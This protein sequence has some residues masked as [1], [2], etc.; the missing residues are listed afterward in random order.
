M[1]GIEEVDADF[2]FDNDLIDNYETVVMN[3]DDFL[4]S[5]TFSWKVKDEDGNVVY[6]TNNPDS[7]IRY[8]YY[9]KE[10]DE[11]VE[12]P[13]LDFKGVEPGT[14]I[15]ENNNLKWGTISGE[16]DAED[17]EPSKLSFYPSETFDDN[18]CEDDAFLQELRYDNQKLDLVVEYSDCYGS[19][20]NLLESE[21]GHFGDYRR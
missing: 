10:K 6:E 21:D 12:A 13:N 15:V 11:E 14:Y 17:F 1:G 2:I 7:I 19:D 4:D 9:D 8:S 5:E 20:F 16:F 3:V 18:I